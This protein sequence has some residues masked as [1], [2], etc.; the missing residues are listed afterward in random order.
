MANLLVIE[1]D[2]LVS[3]YVAMTLKK[4]GHAVQSSESSLR[5][6]DMIADDTPDLILCDIMLPDI[7]GYEVLKAIRSNDQTATLPFVFMTGP[8]FT[9]GHENGHGTRRERLSDQAFH[10]PG[11]HLSSSGASENTGRSRN[12]PSTRL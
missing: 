7:T 9:R 6:L 11:T 4:A 10:T 3:N 2:T 5:A 1:D 12:P 8:G